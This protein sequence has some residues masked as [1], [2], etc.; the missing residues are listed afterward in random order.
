MSKLT[1]FQPAIY[2]I[3]VPGMLDSLWVDDVGPLSLKVEEHIGG[4]PVTILTGP[5]DQAMLQGILRRLYGLKLPLISVSCVDHANVS[6]E[7]DGEN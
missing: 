2:Q 7:D 6:F 3:R 5:M 1:L 4:Q